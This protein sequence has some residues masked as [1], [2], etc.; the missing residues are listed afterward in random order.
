M[1]I[2]I[3]IIQIDMDVWWIIRHSDVCS[4]SSFDNKQFIL[5]GPHGDDRRCF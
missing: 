1:V 3:Q 2:A 5:E 4:L